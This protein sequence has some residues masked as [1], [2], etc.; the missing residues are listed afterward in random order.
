MVNKLMPDLGQ[1]IEDFNYNTW[2]VANWS[3]LEKRITGPEFQVGGWKWCV[4]YFFFK[5]KKK[6]KKK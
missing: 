6:K 1:E 3:N 2:H 5:I 4:I